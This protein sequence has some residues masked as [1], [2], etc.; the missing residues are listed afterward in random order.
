MS[1]ITKIRSI[2]VDALI[3]AVNN[4][5]GV[6]VFDGLPA[7]IDENTEL[8]AIAVHISDIKPS[9]EYLDEDL[10]RATLHITVLEQ[11][12]TPD[13]E[14]DDWVSNIVIPVIDECGALAR[15]CCS[16]DYSGMEYPRNDASAPCSV[17]DV[18]YDITYEGK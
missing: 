16:I 6:V 18:L 7:Y 3:P 9:G 13:S 10:W 8:P 2:V 5:K 14:L 17:V 12:G 4:K 1:V 11:M 15:R